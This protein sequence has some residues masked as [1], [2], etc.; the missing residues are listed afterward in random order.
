MFLPQAGALPLK[1]QMNR[2]LPGAVGRLARA[3]KAWRRTSASGLRDLEDGGALLPHHAQ[4]CART[5][6]TPLGSPSELAFTTSFPSGQALSVLDAT[7]TRLP[8]SMDRRTRSG[9][10]VTGPPPAGRR[11]VGSIRKACAA[12][13]S[14]RRAMSSD[15][16]W[17]RRA[18]SSDEVDVLV[19]AGIRT[20]PSAVGHHATSNS[21]SIRSHNPSSTRSL[22][23]AA[24]F[25]AASHN[26]HSARTSQSCP[27]SQLT[28]QPCWLANSGETPR[29]RCHR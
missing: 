23:M 29:Q 10:E 1:R 17:C 27:P 24:S 16:G 8:Q 5:E 6:S 7:S 18:M 4:R 15:A 26:P 2:A 28:C 20:A 25:A 21:G 14:C 19:G 22:A 13:G 9:Q 12:R 11:P 3:R